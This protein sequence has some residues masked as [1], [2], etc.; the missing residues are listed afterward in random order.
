MLARPQSSTLPAD[1]HGGTSTA[2]ISVGVSPAAL[3]VSANSAGRP[4]GQ[5]NP[6]FSGTLTG[7][8]NGDN[9]TASYASTAVTNS[10]A[11]G[12]P[13]VPVLADP[14]GRLVN[15]TVS[16]TNGILTVSK[17]VPVVNWPTPT[18]IVYG[19]PLG[20]N[21]NN[22]A[23]TVPGSFSYNP[24]NG[25]VLPAGTNQLTLAFT[26]GD[27]N[28]TAVNLTN[29]L[30]VTPAPLSVSA[31]SAGRPYGQTNPV[32]S[33][34]LTGVVNGDNIT[35]SYASTA[36]TNSPAGGY[37]IV[38]VLADPDGRLVNYTVSST[39]GIL[40]VSKGVPVVN[41]PTPTNIV[42][43]TPLGT[44]QNNAAST[45][46][47]SFSYNPTNGVVLP[48]GTNQLTLAFTPG[49]TNYTAVNLT[50]S[51]VVTPAPLSVSANSA[52]RPYGQTNPVFSGTLTG[53]VN[54]DN[55]TASY[56][57]TAVTNSPAGGYPI[58]PVL[59]DPD[60]R[61]VNYT[62]SSTNGILTVSKGVPVVNWP[63]PTNIVYGTP[64]GTNQNNA[65][66]TV[67]GSFSYNPTNGV[68]LPAGTN[69]LTLAFT[70]GDTN[71]TAVNLTNSLV[72]TPAPLSVSAN[73]AGRPYG[74]TNPVF[75]GTL[76]GVV[77]GDNITASY[78]STAVTNSP[79]GGYPIVP[80]LADPD[81]RLVNYTVSSTNGILTVS[82]GVPVVNWPTPT[83]IVYGTPLGTNQNNAASTVPGSFSYNPTNGVV[84]PAG[85]NQL[86]LAFTPGDTNYTAVNLTNSL[87]VTPAPL[88][89]S[90][91]SAGRPYGQT[92]P[93]FS[94]TLTGVVN[95]DNITASYA[96]TAVTN[97][98]AGGYPIVPVL[99][100]PDGRLVNYTVSSTNGILT[101]T[102][103]TPT[104][105]ADLIVFLVGPTNVNV[106]DSFNYTIMLTNG[107]PSNASNVVVVDDL[108]A[109]LSFVSA[110]GGGVFSNNV[111][112]WPTLA[113]FTNGATTN[114]TLTVGAPS[115]G[116][117]TN[118]ASAT[119][120]TPDPNPTNNVG[121]S[122]VSQV[123]P[124]VA[125][126]QFSLLA[127]ATTFNPQTGLYEESVVVTN[128]GAT[129][130]AGV[131]LYVG[132]LR[133]GVTLYNA[134]GTTN[135]TPYV[136]YDA[137]LNPGSTVTF[138]LEF[139]DVNRLAFTNAL[140]AVEIPFTSLPSAGTNGVAVTTEF[141][142]TRL[143]NDV[144]FVVE[145]P[146]VPGKSYTIIY[147]ADM[148][149]WQVATPSVTVSANITQWYDD[150]PPKTVSKPTTVNSR[151]YRVIQD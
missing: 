118:F 43:G 45:V 131:R 110:S 116:L 119:S 76:T 96:S 66:S 127:G 41:W 94:G 37:P 15:Y 36:V 3:S 138:A 146:T 40:T 62:V 26:P 78:A 99:A 143:T 29:S 58:V 57:S 65:A 12:Y 97:S 100:D 124:V 61:L 128:N 125:S 109:S 46:P 129:T 132:G 126:A 136:E 48:A 144:R 114:F 32:F 79:A 73:S 137:S 5:T 74:Q 117:F 18:N 113:S 34:T 140:T 108:P 80:V 115:P 52:G 70:P 104:P 30:V 19:T 135:G 106:G 121:A 21:Q 38:P 39:N 54:G 24:T 93:V 25:V 49:D 147:S 85:T 20:T 31:N 103:S 44:N 105:S 6:V 90:A 69:Q 14:D 107:G 10:P 130:V 16:S 53:V 42:Y 51:L 7:V 75:S 150:G 56:A 84:L 98:P 133:S 151:F 86:T 50:N 47:G 145:F 123:Q 55:I 92:N 148:V 139:Y 13:I 120:T 88:S 134:T 81:G 89:V 4:Y 71:Y 9:I 22:A 68:V 122:L 101:V 17:G 83:N 35:A 102:N 27:T 72:V 77:N 112:T 2:I 82:K 87:V 141:M 63:T 28:Y 95:G 111:V 59:A 33:G 11:G 64:L 1:A 91:N 149:T 8:V 60:G 142:D 67:P 23:S